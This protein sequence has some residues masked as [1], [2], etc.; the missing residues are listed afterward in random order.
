M[1]FSKFDFSRVFDASPNASAILHRDL[2]LVAANHAFLKTLGLSWNEIAGK[3]V[4]DVVAIQDHDALRGSFQRVIATGH[5]D[6]LPFVRFAAQRTFASSSTPI[7]DDGGEI[8]WL[9]VQIADVTELHSDPEVSRILGRVGTA[10]AEL[11]MLRHVFEQA[12]GFACFLRGPEHRFELANPAYLALVGHDRSIIGKPIA[13]ALPEVVAQGFVELLDRVYTTGEAY[14]GHATP[15]Q[16]ARPGGFETRILDFVYQP[17]AVD[18]QSVG[19]FVQGNDITDARGL[20]SKYQQLVQI[21][22]QQVWSA[23]PDGKLDSVNDVAVEYFKRTAEQLI[24]N[25]WADLVHPDDRQ[26]TLERWTHSIATGESY[27]NE[28]RLRR[29]DGVYHWYLARAI[30]VRAEDHSIR[31]WIGTN[32]D[33]DKARRDHDELARRAAYEEK[34]IGIVSHDLRNPLGTITL[35][36]SMIEREELSPTAQKAIGYLKAA[37]ARS[38]RLIADLLDFAQARS[39]SFPI[40]PGPTDL[41]ALVRA[42]VENARL[43]TTRRDVTLTHRG[44]STGRWDEGRLT[45]VVANLVGNAFQHAPADAAIRVTSAIEGDRATIEV[46]NQGTAIPADDLPRLFD[47]FARGKNAR[48]KQGRSVGLGLYIA[49]QIT[50]AHRGEIAVTSDASGTTFTVT[51]PVSL[52]A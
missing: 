12:P 35:A 7:V 49:R 46:F 26:V 4:F 50:L 28:F 33:I 3:S 38:E 40:H 45:Q 21:V 36:V 25:D 16:L 32:T 51:L 14:V 43:A 41:Q 8:G 22:P 48:T 37:S 19:V 20:E 5:R 6:D 42:A 9:L 39:G 10:T 44:P 24:G 1:P 23:G 34:L 11:Q 47:P 52:D 18:G 30:A 17:I 2:H 27:Q 15:V 29:A 13:E 31:G